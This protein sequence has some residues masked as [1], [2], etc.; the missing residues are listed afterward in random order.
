M[1]LRPQRGVYGTVNCIS[2]KDGQGSYGRDGVIDRPGLRGYLL[3]L[4]TL[5]AITFLHEHKHYF[6]IAVAIFLAQF[7][8]GNGG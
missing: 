5:R 6:A 4:H 1:L 7:F 2:W 3:H 8:R